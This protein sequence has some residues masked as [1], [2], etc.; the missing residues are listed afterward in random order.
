MASRISSKDLLN[1]GVLGWWGKE[2]ILFEK[3]EVFFMMSGVSEDFKTGVEN[4]GWGCA[5]D[6]IL[7]TVRDVEERV[8]F[9][10]FKDGPGELRGWGMWDRSNR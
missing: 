1:Q 10:I 7:G 8:V 3:S 6:N 2:I 4:R 9:N 5:S